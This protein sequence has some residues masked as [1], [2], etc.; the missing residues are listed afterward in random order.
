M[1]ASG[2]WVVSPPPGYGPARGVVHFLGGAFAG[3]APQLLYRCAAHWPA[4]AR[5][6]A[7]ACAC[8]CVC[9]H[10]HSC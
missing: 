10:V 1:Q 7:C 4:R 6:C 2:A 9:M 3:A 5:A 8:A